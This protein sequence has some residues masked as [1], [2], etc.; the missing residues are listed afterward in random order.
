MSAEEGMWND[1]FHLNYFY[2][3]VG[4]MCGKLKYVMLNNMDGEGI[5]FIFNYIKNIEIF[6]YK[7]SNNKLSII[8]HVE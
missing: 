6:K 2:F 8:V 1:A 5:L 3:T 4:W 7:R